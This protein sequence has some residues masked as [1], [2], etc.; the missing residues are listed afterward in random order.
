MCSRYSMFD[1][2][3]VFALI[4]QNDFCFFSL[5]KSHST[6]CVERWYL[7]IAKRQYK[8]ASIICTVN[9]QKQRETA[10]NGENIGVSWER[11][12]ITL[13]QW[14][15]VNW[16]KFSNLH[17]IWFVTVFRSIENGYQEWKNTTLMQLF[18]FSQ[19]LWRNIVN[20]IATWQV[21]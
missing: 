11:E 12:K 6:S 7:F 10:K 17:T 3:N 20:T 18:H 4:V 15:Q 21:L 19:S 8:F 1:N 2:C 13:F 16:A 5:R 9:A 14:N